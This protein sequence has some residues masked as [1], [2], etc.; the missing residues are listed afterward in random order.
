MMK[1][2]LVA[3]K[4]KFQMSPSATLASVSGRSRGQTQLRCVGQVRGVFSFRGLASSLASH[5]QICTAFVGLARSCLAA[6]SVILNR[7]ECPLSQSKRDALALAEKV[8]IPEG[9]S[10]RAGMQRCIQGLRAACVDKPRKEEAAGVW[11]QAM[12][13][14]C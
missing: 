4:L 10:M 12:G 3:V 8:R 14:E 7:S 13:K 2:F 6:F 11:D 5:A 9:F 1:S